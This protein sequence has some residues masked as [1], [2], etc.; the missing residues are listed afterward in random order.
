MKK[1]SKED[2]DNLLSK[3]NKLNNIKNILKK[4][5]IGLNDIIDEICNLVEPWYLFPSGQIRPTVVNLH[6]MTGVGKT[7]LIIR[8]LELLDIKSVLKFDVGEWVDKSNFELTNKIS[9]QIKK[10]EGD[11]MIPVFIFDEF[12]LG[13]T[14]DN[15]GD[16]I[17]RPSLRII[18]DLLDSGKFTTIEENWESEYI[19]KLYTKLYH[20]INIKNVEVKNGKVVKN[21]K[22]WDLIFLEDS[23]ESDLSERDLEMV[24]KY[25]IKDAFIPVNEISYLKKF[26]EDMFFSEVQM[27]EYLKKLD[28]LEILRFVEKTIEKTST[29]VE[30]DFSSSIIF[31]IGNLDSA[32]YN[33]DDM[34]PDLDADSLYEQTS[35]INLSDIK[36]SLTFLYRP[37]QISRLGNNHIIY[38]SFNEQMYKDLI[39]LELNKIKTK[40]NDKFEIDILFND[41][42]HKLI[43][44]E[45][46]FPTQG[47]R[48]VFSTITS[49]IESNIGR[50]VVD[51]LLNNLDTDII[52][53]DF[54]GEKFKVTLKAKKKKK[55]FEYPVKLKID[56]IRKT[57]ADDLQSLVGIHEAG[58]VIASIY[59]LNILPKMVVS[60]PANGNGGFTHIEFPE[61]ETRNIFTKEIICLL[62]G[63]AAEKII[64][65]ENNISDGSYSDIEKTTRTAL[66][67]IKE[68]GLNGTPAIYGTPDFRI[69]SSSICFNN[70]ELDKKAEHIIKGCLEFCEKLLE[71]NMLLLLK[72]GEYLTNNS[73]MNSEE[74]KDMV[75]LY[76]NSEPT[77]KTK[78]NYYDYKSV[79]SDKLKK[80]EN[81]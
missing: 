23:L 52:E 11:H 13:R 44:S 69:S 55:V 6:G 27:C 4:E 9:S 41:N 12:Q 2:K 3:H 28:G 60:K 81:L 72:M 61:W 68:Y 33:A 25:Y 56:N 49:L 5:F 40:I 54:M 34:S 64:F 37:E 58:H 35:K 77:Y 71:D 75:K 43:Y 22:E 10:I 39:T 73:K 51:S 50:I 78:D 45:G 66:K 15:V 36:R 47:V 57:K 42:I 20:L 30:Y 65:G 74:I 53:W 79:M 67:M 31:N 21:K 8:L 32:Y 1:I 26:N 70:D 46:V 63:Y 80:Y 76:G 38:K 48:P 59:S 16:E 7:S 18:W 17:D 62:A 24:K 29:P 19:I 14:I